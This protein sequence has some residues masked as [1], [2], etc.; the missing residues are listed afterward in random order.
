[1]SDANNL[2]VLPPNHKDREAVREVLSRADEIKAAYIDKSKESFECFYRGLTIASQ[3]GPR[4]F[5]T[6]MALFQRECLQAVTPSLEAVRVGDMPEMRQFW[7]ERTKKASK[8]ADLAVMMIWLVAF[9][10]RPLYMQIG[11]ADR[12]QA[13]IVKDRM[14]HLLH[15]NS[16]LNDYV[17]MVQNEIR[18][19]RQ[20]SNGEPLAKIEIKSSDV[21]GAHG[22]TPDV[23]VI[24]ELSHITKWEFAENLK[25][26]AAGVAQGL[27]IIATNAGIK[28]TKAEVWR[29]N[30]LTSPDWSCWILARPAPWHSAK[31][32]KDEKATL[33]I[34]K[35]MRLWWGLWASGK[36]DAISEE[37][38]DRAFCLPGPTIA[39]EPGWVYFGGVDLGVT[40]DHAGVVIVGAHV[41]RQIAKLVWMQAWEPSVLIDDKKEVDLIELETKGIELSRIYRLFK[42][43]Y[44]PHQAKLMAQ[45][46]RRAN[47]PT[48]EVP[49]IP[50]NLGRMADCL[51]QLLN[52]GR[53]QLFDDDGRLRRDI[54]KFNIV[55]KSYGHRLE[56]TSDEFG[57]ADVG[58]ALVL[59]LPMIVD[60]LDGI[61]DGLGPDEDLVDT[62]DGELTED[63]IHEMPDELKAIYGD[64]DFSVLPKTETR[65]QLPRSAPEK[66]HKPRKPEP[67]PFDNYE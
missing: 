67:D 2:P 51:L 39:P 60:F 25:S 31:S 22:G 1:M 32:V 7:I 46:W 37:V 10:I 34:G 17:E 27:I 35:F 62:D 66:I 50:S 52:E 18:S 44:D 15:H 9:P 11:A 49:F 47:V 21:A 6:C 4:V 26:N 43:G 23:L 57:H 61:L 3:T 55:E 41:G 5:E 30:A 45:R 16:W 48:R 12:V 24:N 56:A 54:G 13:G 14:S 8:D 59:M 36:G 20:M 42:M 63:E 28:G 38:I 65:R 29:N 33:P 64:E 58:T 19:K 53:L 40:H